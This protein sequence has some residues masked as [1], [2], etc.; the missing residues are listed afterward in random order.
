MNSKRPKSYA[1]CGGAFGDEGKG[2]I[3]DMLVH[4][5]SKDGEVIVYRDNGGANAGHTVEF[6]NGQRVSFHQLPSGIFIKGATVVLGKEMVIH[7]GD[8]LA[9]LEQIREV[10]VTKDRAEIRIDELAT[11]ALDTH[12]AFETVLKAWQSGGKGSTGRG[13]APAYADVLLRHPLR[14]RDIITFNAEK[15]ARHYEMYAALTKGLGQELA[16]VMVS[17]LTG[18]K[19]AVGSQDEFITRL[20]MQA[21]KLKPLTS[22]LHEWLT[23]K[24]Q[25]LKCSFVFEKAQAVGLDVRWGVYPDVT[26]SDT[27][28][29]GIL[30]ATEGVIDPERIEM[31]AGVIKATYMSSVGTRKLPSMMESQLADRIRQDAHEYGA[32]TKRPR[33]IA[34][35]DIPA[36]Q[37]FCKMGKINTLILTH[38]DISY[39]DQPIKICTEYLRAKKKVEYRPDQ[40]FLDTVTPIYKELPSWDMKKLTQAKTF[41]ALPKE[42]KDFLR[43]IEKTIGVPVSMITTG[44]RREQAIIF[45]NPFFSVTM[46]R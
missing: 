22:D 37:F 6:A 43:F 46:K 13:I 31:K 12:R 29:A 27:T 30:S 11:L 28:F 32:T 34:Y 14:M 18:E 19:L 7:P 10:T 5:L 45:D 24:W 25:D 9:E 42:A 16:T 1:I 4:D 39:S 40:E 20:K 8:L 23:E 33:D 15:V 41:E 35:L 36:L 44:P 26:A 38:M 3:V 21:E 2:R 17:T